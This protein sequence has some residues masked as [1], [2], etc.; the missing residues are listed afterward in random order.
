MQFIVGKTYSRREISDGLGGSIRSYL[1][2]KAGRVVCGCFKRIPEKNP[3]AP[4]EVTIGSFGTEFR[5]MAEQ[6]DPIPIF[7]FRSS[8]AWEY[9]GLYRCTGATTDPTV[10]QKKMQENPKRGVI[11]GVLYFER[12][13]SIEAVEKNQSSPGATGEA[14]T[15]LT[16]V[17][18]A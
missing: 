6:D 7:L 10:L 12:A 15:R 14:P 11:R 3:R 5:L 8:S 4:E 16:T 18:N 1:P 2:T 17:D 13:D 9:V